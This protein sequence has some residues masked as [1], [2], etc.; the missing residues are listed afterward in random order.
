MKVCSGCK[1]S[2]P[3]DRFG[4]NNAKPDGKQGACRECRKQYNKKYYKKTKDIHN[5]KRAERRDWAKAE[6]QKFV[7]SKLDECVDCGVED[8]R[9]LEFDHLR[10]KFMDIS[11]MMKTGYSIKKISQEID[12]CEVVCRNC[13]AIRTS[14]RVP[15]YRSEYMGVWQ[16]GYAPAS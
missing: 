16:N 13:H 10:D 11:S 4:K 14:E 5:P 9:V 8:K 6:A 2:L 3:L 12:K 15:N 7:L 1:K